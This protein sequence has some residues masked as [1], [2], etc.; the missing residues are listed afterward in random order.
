MERTPAVIFDRD[1]TL[2][3]VAYIAP[4]TRNRQDWAAF[5]AALP[6]DA[7]VPV[8]AALLRSIRP[9]VKRIVTSGRMAGDYRG[10]YRRWGLMWSWLRKHDLPVDLL[11]MRNGGDTR[12]DSVV[13]L[14]M[15]ERRI[16]PYYDVRYVIDD[17]QQVVDMWRS[18]GLPVLQVKDPGILPPI[19]RQVHHPADLVD[20][21]RD[22]TQV[23]GVVVQ[24]GNA[25]GLIEQ[26]LIEGWTWDERPAES[27]GGKRIRYLRT[28]N[29]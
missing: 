23:T 16:S 18:L 28:P 12:S 11:Y 20:H 8:V 26:L 4:A 29:A 1:G 2:A 13:K 10:D 24:D 5:N 21:L 6:F 17:R 27:V 19:A 22:C 3:S 15:Y 25:D 9:G 7:P 14:E